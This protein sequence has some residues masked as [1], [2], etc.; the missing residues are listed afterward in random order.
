VA[1]DV[2][3]WRS[4]NIKKARAASNTKYET[5]KYDII[6]LTSTVGRHERR[7][8]EALLGGLSKSRKRTD[9][10]R[11]HLSPLST[12]SR[13]HHDYEWGDIVRGHLRDRSG[14]IDHRTGI[15]GDSQTSKPS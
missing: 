3:W 13:F 7:Q 10:Y 2:A 6:T 8:V 4:S 15:K 9:G 11:V 14:Q 5:R 1:T 12:A